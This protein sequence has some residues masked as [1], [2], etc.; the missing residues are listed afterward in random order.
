MR[1]D[2]VWSE[3][4]HAEATFRLL[5]SLLRLKCTSLTFVCFWFMIATSQRVPEASWFARMGVEARD[6]VSTVPSNVTESW[7]LRSCP[8]PRKRRYRTL[9]EMPNPTL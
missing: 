7:R 3:V 2:V 4:L 9:T 1:D 5:V 8:I 6:M